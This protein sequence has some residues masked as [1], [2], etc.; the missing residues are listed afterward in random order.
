MEDRLTSYVLKLKGLL[1]NLFSEGTILGKNVLGIHRL[2]LRKQIQRV[3]GVKAI[4][5]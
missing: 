5:R 1:V 4:R 2:Q 3:V